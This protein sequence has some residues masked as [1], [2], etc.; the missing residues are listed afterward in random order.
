MDYQEKDIEYD[1]EF[2]NILDEKTTQRQ[3]FDQIKKFA[4]EKALKGYN[5][6]ILSYG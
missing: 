5:S 2:Q 1:F 6:C 3:F 4:I